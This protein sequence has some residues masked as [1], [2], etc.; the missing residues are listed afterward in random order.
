[1]HK[2]GTVE[3][4]QSLEVLFAVTGELLFLKA[5]FPTVISW[6]GMFLVMA[7]MVLHSFVSH[8]GAVVN[9]KNVSA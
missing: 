3:A 6:A 7:G 4:T 1:M 5:A 9:R 2:L 8:K